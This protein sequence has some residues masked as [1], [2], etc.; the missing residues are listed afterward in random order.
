MEE[1]DQLREKDCTHTFCLT[2]QEHMFL[3]HANDNFGKKYLQQ[4]YRHVKI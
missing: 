1:D 3:I 2:M 4:N